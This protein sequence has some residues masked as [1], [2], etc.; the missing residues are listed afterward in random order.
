MQ[1]I[2]FAINPDE[3]DYWPLNPAG[4][5]FSSN[6]SI[7]YAD[8]TNAGQRLYVRGSGKGRLGAQFG[9]LGVWELTSPIT[10]ETQTPAQVQVF[11][12]EHQRK[13]M[14]LQWRFRARLI[15]DIWSRCA[16][17]GE[18][19]NKEL[20]ATT[21]SYPLRFSPAPPLLN[22]EKSEELDRVYNLNHDYDITTIAQ[23]AEMFRRGLRRE[24]AQRLLTWLDEGGLERLRSAIAY[25][26]ER[27]R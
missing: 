19:S 18:E 24:E 5:T 21:S 6:G 7:N 13:R 11:K 16:I 1:D 17:N 23:I 3:C 14:A 12:D 25:Q 27:I 4:Q 26:L 9:L 20:F 8:H 22:R 10:R 2:L 15:H